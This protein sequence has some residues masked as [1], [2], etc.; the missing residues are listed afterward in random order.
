V[1]RIDE[2]YNSLSLESPKHKLECIFL[3]VL[4]L[5]LDI[6]HNLWE[7]TNTI[8]IGR[9][10]LNR[11]MSKLLE[12]KLLSNNEVRVITTTSRHLKAIVIIKMMTNTISNG[13]NEDFKRLA[14]FMESTWAL[15][16]NIECACSQTIN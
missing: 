15:Y 9:L 10:N 11:F 2:F 13:D 12:S 1:V 7:N 6:W 14:T 16:S 8:L 3:V 4:L 5:N